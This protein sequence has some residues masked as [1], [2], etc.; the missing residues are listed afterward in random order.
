MKSVIIYYSFSGNTK[1]VADV[2]SGYLEE[3][4]SVETIEIKSL[5]ESD[6]FLTQAA[7]AFRRKRAQIAAVNFDLCGYDLL[8]FGTPVWAFG[9]APAM[10]TYLD[11]C[12]GIK[13]KEV[14]LFTTY[15][16]GTGN[17]RCLNYMQNI[18]TKK[19]AQKFKRFSIQQFKVN[20]KELVFSKIK[21]IF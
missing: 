3:K 1:K 9:P 15:G 2:L 14:V 5:D 13:D 6:K 20:D 4:G 12:L 11:K 10:N 17:E 18:L 21:E 16:S 8:C 19:G 7:R